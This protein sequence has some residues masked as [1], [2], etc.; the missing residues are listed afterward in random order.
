LI[1]ANYAVPRRLL[2]PFLPS[3][4]D[5]DERDGKAWASIVAFSFE[6]TRVLGVPWPG[7]RNFPEWNLRFYVRQG[8][9]RGVCFVREIVPSAW[10]CFMA[11]AIYNEPYSPAPMA[12][13]LREEGRERRVRYDLRWRGKRYSA[14]VR[15]ENHPVL[16]EPGSA[17][18]FFKEQQW[19]FGRT[20]S[21]RTVVYE[22]CHPHW[23]VYPVKSHDLRLDWAALYG[24][25]WGEMQNREPDSVFLARGSRVEVFP[26]GLLPR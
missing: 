24:D 25:Q 21:G 9:R 4:V 13:R 7:F 1:L 15:A 23:D 16:P 11:R 26:K 19:G 3:G 12:A 5:L 18:H 2:A 14:R 6:D 10:V 20:R 17:E 22:V 8:S